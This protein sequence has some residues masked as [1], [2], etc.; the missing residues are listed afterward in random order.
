MFALPQFT[1]LPIASQSSPHP[2]GRRRHTS[3]NNKAIRNI[4]CSDRAS[5]LIYRPGVRR[6]LTDNDKPDHPQPCPR[7]GS[8]MCPSVMWPSGGRHLSA[9]KRRQ[10]MVADLSRKEFPKLP[11]HKSAKQSDVI[12][13]RK[14]RKI[15]AA[16]LEGSRRPLTML[17]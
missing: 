13:N 11:K 5:Q 16:C 10:S 6:I 15:A 9:A 14:P 2:A 12:R 1:A 8:V 4:S 7:L 17:A 3:R